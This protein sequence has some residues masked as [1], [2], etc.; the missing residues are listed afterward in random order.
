MKLF[1]ALLEEKPR[2]LVEVLKDSSWRAAVG[3]I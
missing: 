3:Q 2:E 1:L